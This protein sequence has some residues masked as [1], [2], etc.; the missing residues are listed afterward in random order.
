MNKLFLVLLSL[1]VST[2]LLAAGGGTGTIM[3]LRFPAIN[4]ILLFGTLGFILRK[5]LKE[6]FDKNAEDVTSLFG[7]AEEKDKEAQLKLDE[8]KRKLDNL[9]SEKNKIIAEAE[10]N[11]DAFSKA[12]ATETDELISRLH[13]DAKGR[14]E[15]ESAQMNRNLSATLLDEVINKVKEK[16]NGDKSLQDKA[17]KKLVSQI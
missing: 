10:Q 16:V 8:Y 12:H 2:E 14:V 4:F 7:L 15:G 11:A 3:D 5:P 13:S 6:M 9:E 1:L 17:T